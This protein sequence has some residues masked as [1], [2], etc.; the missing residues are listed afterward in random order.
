VRRETNR[1]LSFERVHVHHHT[2]V[3]EA[4]HII[5]HLAAAFPALHRPFAGKTASIRQNIVNLDQ[6]LGRLMPITHPE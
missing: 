6:S 3:R 2:Q 5:P 1:R 4:S